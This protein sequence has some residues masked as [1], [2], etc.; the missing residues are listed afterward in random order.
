MPGNVPEF[1]EEDKTALEALA[2]EAEPFFLPHQPEELKTGTKNTRHRKSRK[3]DREER[4]EG[5]SDEEWAIFQ[6]TSFCGGVQ[7]I[8]VE[9]LLKGTSYE[10]DMHQRIADEEKID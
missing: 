10:K 6:S 8:T 2:D 1:T 7:V 5:V 4:P 3:A 9:E